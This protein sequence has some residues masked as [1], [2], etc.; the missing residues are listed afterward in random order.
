MVSPEM[1]AVI[2]FL[3]KMKA[4]TPADFE[5]NDLRKGLDKMVAMMPLPDDGIYESIDAGGVPAEWISVPGAGKEQVVLYLHGGGYISGSIASHRELL[6]RLARETGRYVLAIDYRLAPENPF[7]AALEDSVKAYR[8]LV[9]DQQINPTNIAIAGDSAGGG[10][11]L[12]TLLKLKADGILLP[13]AAVC[14]S[15]WTDLAMTGDSITTKAADD[16]FIAAQGAVKI[17]PFYINGDDPQNPLISPLYGDLVGLPPL[18]IH[19]GSRECL[20]DDSIRFA[21]KANEA[22]VPV[23]LAVW[24]GMIHV[25]HLFAAL[26]PEGREGIRKI[27]DFLKTA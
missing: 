7:P 10:L 15:P 2:D 22:G 17:A 12:A 13:Q 14:L 3:E 21:E 23:T 19:V 6:T 11:T 16:P 20:L 24:E 25:F 4:R 9:S 1:T 8:W 18:L 5:V 27:A 26:A